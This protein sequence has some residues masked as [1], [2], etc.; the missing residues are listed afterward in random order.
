MNTEVLLA[1]ANRAIRFRRKGAKSSSNIAPELKKFLR[2]VARPAKRNIS[3]PDAFEQIAG[4]VLAQNCRIES[5]AAGVMKVKVK[6]GPYMFELRTRAGQI[7]EQL[8]QQCPSSN[9]RE[10]K[11][12]CLE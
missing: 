2:S 9:I 8:K 3:V 11:L 1:K 10:I 7:V 6:S 4:N 12:V 5:L